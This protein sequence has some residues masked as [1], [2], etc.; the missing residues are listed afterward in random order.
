[1]LLDFRAIL[2]IRAALRK[3]TFDIIHFH[4]GR[5]ALLAAIAHS[6]AGRGR[7]IFTQHFISPAHDATSGI[8]RFIKRLIHRWVD[9]QTDR[10]IAISRAVLEAAL[11][12]NPNLSVK[13]VQVWNGIQDP[14]KQASTAP[15]T[16]KLV[17]CD[18]YDIKL[19]CVARLEAEK[20]LPNLLNCISHLRSTKRRIHCW[21]AGGGSQR[22]LLEQQCKEL[23]IEDEISFLGHREDVLDL[24]VEADIIVLPTPNESFGLALV[25][26]MASAKPVIAMAAGGPLEIVEHGHSGLLVAPNDPVALGIAIVQLADDRGLRQRLGVEARERYVTSFTAVR[27]AE[28]TRRVYETAMTTA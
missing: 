13:I 22:N 27:M 6:L 7:L 25:E 16:S 21:V 26:A 14:V 10:V 3:S 4:N 20:G 5:T 24:I 2:R 15:K 12:R 11:R 23:G 28:E 1:M 17:S 18:F 9:F 19:L 8:L